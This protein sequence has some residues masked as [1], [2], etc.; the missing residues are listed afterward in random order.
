MSGAISRGSA[1]EA[2]GGW[3]DGT[4]PD[5]RL[6]DRAA[7]PLALHQEQTQPKDRP[8]ALRRG[9]GHH[10]ILRVCQCQIPQT[11]RRVSRNTLRHT[12][13]WQ[14]PLFPNESAESLGRSQVKC[15]SLKIGN[16]IISMNLISRINF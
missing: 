14:Q 15:T 1:G 10:E 6:P 16:D 9:A 8:D 13:G 5:P 7:R 11:D 3:Q 4:L 2:R 12:A